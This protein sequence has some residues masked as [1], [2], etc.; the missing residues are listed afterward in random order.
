MN[1]LQVLD[2]ELKNKNWTLDEKKRYLYIR[3]CQLLTYDTRHYFVSDYEFAPMIRSASRI[4]ESIHTNEIDLEKMKDN[5]VD[6][7]AWARAYQRMQKELLNAK[8]EVVDNIYG[9]HA[10]LFFG[11]TADATSDSDLTRM[12]MGL[13]SYGYNLSIRE[14]KFVYDELSSQK[15]KK[16]DR[17]IGYIQKNYLRFQPI[18]TVLKEEF[19]NLNLTKEDA[20]MWWTQKLKD[21]FST[22]LP[23]L[24]Y[25][26]DVSFCLEYLFRYFI[27]KELIV[28]CE[29]VTLFDDSN[30]N[31]D[32]VDIYRIDYSENTIYYALVPNANG[33]DFLPISYSDV[34]S[35]V[36]SLK[37]PRKLELLAR[38]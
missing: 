1:V 17:N 9:D 38:R 30:D 34:I 12:K 20:L 7:Y 2:N 27:P 35:F 22:F 28:T 18:V 23:K 25:F 3:S 6:C 26:E 16:M 29:R 5:R 10:W 8:S 19:Q 4:L 11:H 13:E 14:N 21:T 37:G 15:L 36:Q 31:W 32:F 33:Y 24:K